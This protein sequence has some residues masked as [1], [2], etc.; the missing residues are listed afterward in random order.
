M[1]SGKVEPAAELRL[2]RVVDVPA[3]KKTTL[4]LRY[5]N[6][7]GR[8]WSLAVRIDRQT[9]L[10]QLVEDAG[11]VNGWREAVIDLTPFAGRRVPVQL[12]QAVTP[13]QPASESLWKRATIVVE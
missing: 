12:I 11:S 2:L 9:L 6:Q 10:E 3:G 7:P 4:R 1:L 8:N 13:P 5:G